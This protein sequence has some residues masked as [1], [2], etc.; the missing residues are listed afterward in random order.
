MNAKLVCEVV[1]V[2]PA[3]AALW[4]RQNRVNRPVDEDLVRRYAVVMKSGGWLLN[5]KTV[6]FDEDGLMRNGQHRCMAAV[7]AEV[8]FVTVVVRGAS[9]EAFSNLGEEK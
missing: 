6:V 7:Q 2:T 5:G 9:R 3:M 8:G 4:L 1:E